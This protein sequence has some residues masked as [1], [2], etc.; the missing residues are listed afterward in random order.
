MFGTASL[1]AVLEAHAPRDATGLVV[2]LSGG[3]DSAC[4]ATALAQVRPWRGLSLRAIH[5]DHGLQPAAPAFRAACSALCLRLEVPLDLAEVVVA[6][7]GLSVEAAAREARY[8]EFARKLRAGECL[9][10]AHHAAD[11]AETLLLQLL[12]GAGLKGL[13]GMPWCR[14]LGAGWHLRPLLDTPKPELVRFATEH[15]VDAVSD[16]MNHDLRFDRAFLRS[17]LWPLIEGRWPGATTALTRA[18]HHLA[19][20]QALLDQAAERA[21]GKLT[22]GNGLHVTGLRVLGSAERL[23]AVRHWLAEAGVTPPST[24]RLTEA[25]RQICDAGDDRLPCVVWGEHA[26]RRYRGRVFVTPACHPKIDAVR[27]WPVDPGSTLFLGDGLGTLSFAPQAGGLDA[28]RLPPSLEVR[29]RCGGESLKPRRRA[30]TTSVQHLC[31]SRGVLP[32]MRDALPL[33]F[34]GDALIAVGDLWQDAR[35]CVPQH[36]M[37]LGVTWENAPLLV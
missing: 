32:W 9:L 19:D 16:P 2:A 10:T 24:A 17:Q 5:V 4:L 20:A 18:A 29:R 26:L 1:H 3:L 21:L 36:A 8:R 28:S 6:T 30:R 31:Q 27:E 33:L 15:G 35:W 13:A 12:R 11:Q 25:L 23:N 37:G 14:P 7:D 22:D 34:A